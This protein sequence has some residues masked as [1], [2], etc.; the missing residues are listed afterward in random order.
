[1]LIHFYLV[2]VRHFQNHTGVFFDSLWHPLLAI[3]HVRLKVVPA[4]FKS[5]N[6]CLIYAFREGI[7]ALGLSQVCVKFPDDRFAR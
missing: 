2:V 6:T 5:Y 1:M 3:A 4:L 7:A